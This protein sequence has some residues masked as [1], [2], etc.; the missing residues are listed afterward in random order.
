VDEPWD[1]ADRP[2]SGRPRTPDAGRPGAP[3]Q[4][5]A[6]VVERFFAWLQNSRRL[7]TRWER[8]VEN[9]VAMLQLGCMRILFNRL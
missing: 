7:V 8:H 3:T 4:Q 2:A 5:A 1:R 9:F 6:L